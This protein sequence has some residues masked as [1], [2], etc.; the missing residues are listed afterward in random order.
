MA[1]NKDTVY[2]DVIEAIRFNKL[3]HFDYIEGFVEPCTKTLY[4]IFPMESDES[5]AIKRE[6]SL[7]KI[8][9][10]TK[11]VNRWEESE[12]ATLQIA[13]F[14]LIATDEERESLSTNWTKADHTSKGES[15]NKSPI[16]FVKST[17]DD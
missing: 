8:N 5:H 13:A 6:L 15:I 3:K 17:N 11:M 12:N 2:A 9:S 10:K 14:K 16:E 7:N 1:Y 4:E